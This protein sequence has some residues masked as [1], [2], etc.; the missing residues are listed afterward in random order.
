MDGGWD[1]NRE[2]FLSGNGA[3]DYK[4]AAD[5]IES[6]YKESRN[7]NYVSN[8]VDRLGLLQNHRVVLV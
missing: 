7:V 4:G 3:A 5:Y 2:L 8:V 1:Q 6:N